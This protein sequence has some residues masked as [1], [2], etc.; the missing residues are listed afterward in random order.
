M[1]SD[2]PPFDHHHQDGF[3]APPI[4]SIQAYEQ[5]R[6]A[7]PVASIFTLRNRT[8]NQERAKAFV[9]RNA[10]AVI[11]TRG[12]TSH[13]EPQQQMQLQRSRSR[14]SSPCASDDHDVFEAAGDASRL[15]EPS[16]THTSTSNVITRPTMGLGSPA[17]VLQ[18][19]RDIP[20]DRSP[21][22]PANRLSQR[23]AMPRTNRPSLLSLVHSA[24]AEDTSDID[25]KD[26]LG[27]PQYSTPGRNRFVPQH[28]VQSPGRVPSG[29]PH[30]SSSPSVHKSRAVAPA[31]KQEEDI[32]SIMMRGATDLRNTKMEAEELRREV[33]FL[34]TQLDAAQKS[35]E[36]C[37]ERVQ[38][39][40][41][42]A[43]R[44]LEGSFRS[45]ANLKAT[46][47]EL[48]S[49]S[50]DAFGITN[51]TKVSSEDIEE[52]RG[53][54]AASLSTVQPLLDDN[55]EFPKAQETKEILAELQT[56]CKQSQQVSELLRER[57]QAVGAEL[58]DAKARVTELEAMQ[59]VDR[60]A[61]R[62]SSNALTQT[63]GQ[64][65]DLA[66]QLKTQQGH[67]YEVLSTA[68]DAQAELEFAKNE[69]ARLV[70]EVSAKSIEIDQLH[71]EREDISKLHALLDGRDATIASLKAISEQVETVT[72]Q[73]NEQCCRISG[74]ESELK[75]K[76]T[77]VADLKTRIEQAEGTL[78]ADRQERD[79]LQERLSASQADVDAYKSQIER[80]HAEV[81]TATSKIRDLQTT[82]EEAR[83]DVVARNEKIVQTNHRYQLLEDR[84]EDQSVTLRLTKEANGDLQVRAPT[85]LVPIRLPSFFQER[86]IETESK[87]AASLEEVTGKFNC[88]VAVLQEQ[89]CSLQVRIKDLEANLH[90]VKSAAATAKSEHEHTLNQRETSHQVFFTREQ[91]RVKAI[92]DELR[93]SRS[94]EGVLAMQVTDLTNEV[95]DL[96]NQLRNTQVQFVETQTKSDTQIVEL[97]M[98]VDQLKADNAELGEV[99]KTIE[100]RYRAGDLNPQERTFIND[101]V[102][103]TQSV[104]EQELVAKGNDLRRRDNTILELRS[105]INI[106]E[107]TLSKHLKSQAKIQASSG[108][109]NRSLI[110]PTTWASS[111]RSSSPA[112]I[113]PLVLRP[114]PE[115]ETN[116][117]NIAVKT[118]AVP[119]RPDAPPMPTI[120]TTPLPTR[121][122]AHG[123]PPL[124]QKPAIV[125][126]A[127]A[128]ASVKAPTVNRPRFT[129]LAQKSSD[130]SSDISDTEDVG[131]RK[132][133]PVILG[134]RDERPESP[135][136]AE[137]EITPKQPKR[138]RVGVRT[139]AGTKQ[140]QEGALAP[141]TV[142]IE[143]PATKKTR[144][145]R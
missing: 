78:Q 9:R 3:S 53:T 112:G 122:P 109:V 37:L 30:P 140:S 19:Q 125:S 21:R 14:Y 74:Y 124:A 33:S 59:V 133:S 34:Q 110:D 1:Q 44:T 135:P 134:K 145:R 8:G 141:K 90:Q 120:H 126:A 25:S 18:T 48:K 58:I 139:R 7:S 28:S 137:K 100:A 77:I 97:Q 79:K 63:A 45:L 31:V 41:D 96:R 132:R 11:S 12:H 104:H 86:I 115:R 75:A 101:L 85:V 84:F 138:P 27:L 113:G 15:L 131:C 87:F 114:A 50:Q 82:I 88:E 26:F 89:K 23:F 42:A 65:N 17:Q 71:N 117:L 24:A 73:N 56:E 108:V 129:K 43:K 72:M 70:A 40:K 111:D 5:R 81:K 94:N 29:T 64:V 69:I 99:S 54:V 116:T 130:G 121:T 92:E 102:K 144:R 16:V 36:E 103:T 105:K 49:Q 35:K 38:A 52:L 107:S 128:R 51:Q 22:F 47:D 95:Q 98:L 60:E 4:Q 6:A 32:S 57:L 123:R 106:L 93:A 83:S 68:A 55:G 80:L 142:H 91:E 39:V 118:P 136:P 10:S 76:D 46:V 13:Q 2:G 119:R 20:G 61:L 66:K 67:L 127:N 143:L 62:S